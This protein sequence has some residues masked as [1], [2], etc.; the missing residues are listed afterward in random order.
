M[1]N[2]VA[3]LTSACL[4][5][6]CLYQDFVNKAVAWAL[7]DFFLPPLGVVRGFLKAFGVI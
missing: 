6:Y 7:F 2:I 1:F 4:W 5:V 3:S